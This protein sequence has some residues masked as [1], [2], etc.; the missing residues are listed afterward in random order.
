L[1][2]EKV[3][4]ENILLFA[5]QKDLQIARNI[6]FIFDNDIQNFQKKAGAYLDIPVVVFIAPDEKEY[7]NWTDK[8]SKIMEFSLAFYNN[9]N[10]TIYIKNPK[11]LKSLAALRRI[12]LHEYIHHFV[13]H[14]WKNPPLWFNEGMAVFFSNDL[15]IDR[16]FNF[17]KNYIFGNSRSLERMKY[18]YPKNRI[19]WESFYAKSGLAVKYLYNHR[20]KEFYRLWDHSFPNRNFD[21][22]FLKSFYFTPK[23]FSAFFEEYSKTHFRAEILLASTG[24]IWGVLP[25]ILI[26]GVVRKKIRNRIIKERWEREIA[27]K[28]ETD[29]GI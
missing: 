5:D 13:N 10:K 3:A 28:E 2:Y 16:E 14:F 15:G 6:A 1:K 9:R 26:I 4:F 24:I 25:L 18:H 19:E 17:I 20:R 12:L 27:V 11:N 21:S 8:S 23:D 7:Q 22:A 29:E